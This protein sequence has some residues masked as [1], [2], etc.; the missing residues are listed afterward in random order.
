M[1]LSICWSVASCPP[2]SNMSQ[3]DL[4]RE[5]FA[6]LPHVALCFVNSVVGLFSSSCVI[7][8]TAFSEFMLSK[9]VL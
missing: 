6:R 7:F 1:S 9:I 2:Y 8:S 3:Q 5:H 4:L